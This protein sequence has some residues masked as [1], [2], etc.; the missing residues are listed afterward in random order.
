M[1]ISLAGITLAPVTG[2][3]AYR[4]L[5]E[6]A[7]R[8]YRVG[9]PRAAFPEIYGVITREVATELRSPR[10]G[11]IEP[12]AISELMGRFC[13]RYLETL[14]WSLDGQR[15]DCDAWRVAYD[16][17]ARRGTIPFQDVILGL[18]AHINYDLA[19]GISQTIIHHDLHRD[20]RMTARFKHDHDHVNVLLRRSV[21]ECFE[22]VVERYGCR[23]SRVAW[24]RSSRPVTFRVVMSVLSVWRERIWADV[25]RLLAADG[26]E[27]RAQ[28]LAGMNRRSGLIARGIVAPSAGWLAGERL[29]PRR[30]SAL[31]RAS[32][33]QVP[34]VD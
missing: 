21:P 31:V 27:A 29:M 18:S 19:V 5:A 13:A 25:L 14:I 16:Y 30:V 1:T 8:L 10:C 17:A 33:V 22:R 26:D 32:L 3:E 11:F 23:F 28:V 12:A 6:V 34:A 20:A 4:S 9:D 15:Q 7:D 2:D 24:H